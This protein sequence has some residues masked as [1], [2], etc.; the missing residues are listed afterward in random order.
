MSAD[1]AARDS[2]G[3]KTR[4]VFMVATVVH[5]VAAILIQLDT[6]EHNDDGRHRLGAARVQL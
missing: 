3:Y 5:Q 4:L 2:R 6:S 1:L